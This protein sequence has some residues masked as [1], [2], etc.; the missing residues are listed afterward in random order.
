MGRSEEMRPEWFHISPDEPLRDLPLNKMWEEDGYWLPYILEKR[1]FIG[2]ADFGH[3]SDQA[4]SHDTASSGK[5]RLQRWWFAV[6]Y[7][8]EAIH[9][10]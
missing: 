2:R 5:V 7:D 4:S 9:T 1:P 10:Q 3:T 8:G 6:E